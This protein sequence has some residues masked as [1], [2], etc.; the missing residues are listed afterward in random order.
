MTYQK[1][2]LLDLV[3]L[4]QNAYDAVDVSTPL[5]RQERVSSLLLEVLERRV[6]VR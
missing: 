5:A 4:Q 3:Y 6:Y 2:W 1:A